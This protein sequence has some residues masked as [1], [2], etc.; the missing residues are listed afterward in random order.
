MQ[1]TN[2]SSLLTPIDTKIESLLLDPNNPRFSELGAELNPVP[3]GR[4]ADDK[5]Q[6]STLEKM[7]TPIFDVSEL[8]DT[9]KTIGFLPMDRVVVREWKGQHPDGQPRYASALSRID[10]PPLARNDPGILN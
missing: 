5:V 9:I 6:A 2:L 3:E 10:P 7:K 1:L 4:F 8:R